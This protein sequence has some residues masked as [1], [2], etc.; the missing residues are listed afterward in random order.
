M[1][2]FALLSAHL[3][4]TLLMV[5]IIW[6]VQVVHY[7]LMAQVGA[8]QF[9]EYARLHQSRTTLVVVG[10]MLVEAITAM[11]LLVRFPTFRNSPVFLASAVL[12]VLIWASTAWLQVPIH[13]SLAQ[14]FDEQGIQ[15]LIESN[16]LRTIAWSI[17][18]VLI[19]GIFWSMATRSR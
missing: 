3:I 5:G 19:C 12:L 18:G 11:G 7:P 4:S 16:W 14:G 8:E 17:R 13:Q 1:K 9:R 15:R 6:F 2:E 10:P